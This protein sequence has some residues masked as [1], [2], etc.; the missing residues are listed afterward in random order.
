MGEVAASLARDATADDTDDELD[1]LVDEL[2]GSKPRPVDWRRLTG[3]AAAQQWA[4]LHAW[5]RWLVGRYAI[6]P[7]EIPPCWGAH[8]ELVEELSALHTAHQA[9][10]D[11]AGA[12]TGPADWHTT[13]ANTRSRLHLSVA[14]TGCRAGQHRDSATPEW[15]AAGQTD[16]LAGRE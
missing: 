14:R 2:L 9:A 8:G 15:V 4:D 16:D 1:A 3:E 7:R 10:Y 11:P 6:D 12:P 5:V 13:L